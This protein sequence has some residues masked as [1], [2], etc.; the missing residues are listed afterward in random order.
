MFHHPDR[1]RNGCGSQNLDGSAG[2][3]GAIVADAPAY[4]R[5]LLMP[6]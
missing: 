6:P 5:M 1:S 2:Q 4:V 3:F